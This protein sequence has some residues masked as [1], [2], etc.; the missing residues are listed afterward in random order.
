MRFSTGILYG[1]CSMNSRQPFLNGKVKSKIQKIEE[2]ELVEFCGTIPGIEYM[3][4]M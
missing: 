3:I 2:M 1:F 4:K